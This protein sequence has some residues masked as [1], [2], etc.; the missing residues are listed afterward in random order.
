M[1]KKLHIQIWSRIFD[2]WNS[3]PAPPLSPAPYSLGEMVFLCELLEK[4]LSG[5]GQVL[6]V[7]PCDDATASDMARFLEDDG[8]AD[9]F[10]VID[11]PNQDPLAPL[12]SAAA[13]LL[14]QPE[15][16]AFCLLDAPG[17]LQVLGALDHVFPR[18]SPQGMVL[19]NDCRPQGHASPAFR[20]YQDYAAISQHEI[21]T[22]GARFGL[23]QGS[24]I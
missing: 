15:K 23:L 10:Q 6:R 19:V 12:D 8:R 21:L 22:P 16:I 18:L 13:S 1:R 17:Y 7:G 14:D 2:R 9:R 5:G 11:L 3:L 4:A 20:A 24:S